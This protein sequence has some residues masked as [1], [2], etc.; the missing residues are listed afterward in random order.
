MSDKPIE[1]RFRELEAAYREAL[2]LA[3]EACGR[4][5]AEQFRCDLLQQDLAAVEA[6]L[7]TLVSAADALMLASSHHGDA[8][9]ELREELRNA[10]KAAK[11]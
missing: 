7:R 2:Q 10:I 4:A 3:N 1:E 8:R 6:K 11:S 9:R 5:D